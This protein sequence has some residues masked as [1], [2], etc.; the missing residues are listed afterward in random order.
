MKLT[1]ENLRIPL[2]TLG[3]INHHDTAAGAVG[4]AGTTQRQASGSHGDPAQ[5]GN[6]PGS[7]QFEATIIGAQD[8]ILVEREGSR[9]R[10]YAAGR[11]ADGGSAVI[12]RLHGD[13]ICDCD[14]PP[15]QEGRVG[16][17]RVVAKID[18]GSTRRPRAGQDQRARVDVGITRIL[19]VC[20]G[21]FHRHA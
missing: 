5:P 1:R 9:E 8:D 2:E 21:K 13:V 6:V 3:A 15:E 17:T 4:L 11:L 18:R 19:I 12:P 16:R 20:A 14:R 7:R 10:S